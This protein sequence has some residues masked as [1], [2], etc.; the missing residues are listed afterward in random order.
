MRDVGPAGVE[1]LA[2][3]RR[4]LRQRHLAQLGRLVGI[5]GGGDQWS[6]AAIWSS[7]WRLAVQFGPQGAADDQ[8]GDRPQ[9]SRARRRPRR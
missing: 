4:E 3:P 1:R 2:G 8:V 7:S 9:R 5:E 6:D